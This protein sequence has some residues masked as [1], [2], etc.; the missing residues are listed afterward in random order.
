[1][2]DL[3]EYYKLNTMSPKKIFKK[4]LNRTFKLYG[5]YK[6]KKTIEGV[7]S[8]DIHEIKSI[9]KKEAYKSGKYD[10]KLIGKNP[11][12]KIQKGEIVLAGVGKYKNKYSK[13]GIPYDRFF[14]LRFITTKGLKVNK[15]VFRGTIAQAEEFIHSNLKSWIETEDS[16]I[17]VTIFIATPEVINDFS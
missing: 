2:K 10:R 5:R 3:I 4:V 17:Y 1:M 9:I 8:S 14:E 16:N 15:Y 11:D 7:T 12:V 6:V 13:T